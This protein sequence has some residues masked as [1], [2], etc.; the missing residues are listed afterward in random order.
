MK[1]PLSKP[2]ITQ[3]EINAVVNVM[4][5]GNLAQGVKVQEFEEHMA[6]YI[7]TKYAVAVSSGTAGLF[8]CLKAIGVGPGDEVITTPFSFIASSNVI[9]HAGARPVFV[10]IDRDTY[11]INCKDIFY[12]LKYAKLKAI[13]PIDIFGNPVDTN[14]I[15]NATHDRENH[16]SIILDSCESLG[17][18][19]NRPFDACVYAFYPNKQITTGEGGM[20][21]TNNKDI[22][23]YCRAARNQ[24]RA[25][26][27]AWLE[28]S[29][30]GWNF[31]MTDIQAAIGIVQMSRLDEIVYKRWRAYE[32]YLLKLPEKLTRYPGW[33]K[34]RSKGD[35]FS[36]FVFTIEVD[37]RD[38]VMRYLLA[39]GIECKPY[40]P[41]IHLQ[42]PY[43][44]MGYHEGMFPVAEEVSRRTLALPFYTDMTEREIDIVCH[45]LKKVLCQEKSHIQK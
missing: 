32:Q 17:S 23:D 42:K 27:D 24:G 20:I 19:M 11:N 1:I 36:P 16:L 39:N 22:A 44:D 5:S 6:E 35:I 25:P 8:L 28:S 21:C 14:I 12:T 3:A 41:C 4:Q 29:M 34:H 37:N 43:K 7:G 18:K 40:F 45:T 2:S 10:D 13:M 38:K 26:G 15:Q 33:M 30:V 9:V 31:R